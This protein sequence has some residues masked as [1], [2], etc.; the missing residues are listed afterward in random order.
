MRGP[1]GFD[2]LPEVQKATDGNDRPE[3]QDRVAVP[4]MRQRRSYED[5]RREVG[6]Q[7]LGRSPKGGLRSR[8]ASVGVRNLSLAVAGFAFNGIDPVARFCR[9]L[10][11]RVTRSIAGFARMLF[12]LWRHVEPFRPLSWRELFQSPMVRLAGPPGAVKMQ[13]RSMH[14]SR[15]VPRIRPP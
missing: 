5:R 15:W 7:P 13:M 4:E 8:P 14:P 2:A 11:L 10:D 9:L 3:R 6:R 12:D 1:D